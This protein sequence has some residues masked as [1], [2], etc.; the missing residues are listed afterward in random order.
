MNP[1]LGRAV[2]RLARQRTRLDRVRARRGRPQRW[3][4][5]VPWISIGTVVT[6]IIGIG[7]L[8]FTGVATYYG[9]QVSKDQLEQSREES[10]REARSQATKVSFWF[11]GQG[12]KDPVLHVLNRSP[13]PVTHPT[14][15]F[16]ADIFATKDTPDTLALGN[17]NLDVLPPCSLLTVRSQQ[18]RTRAMGES[19]KMPDTYLWL[20]QT[21]MIFVDR[22]G[23]SWGRIDGKLASMKQVEARTR[24]M[25]IRAYK[26]VPLHK[27]VEVFLEHGDK[28][29]TTSAPNCGDDSAK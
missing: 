6:V 14:V 1:L 16:V 28:P 20:S 12:T 10:E 29:R 8:A 9:A 7:S 19:A 3:W 17:I 15:A 2:T 11:E 21:Y 18:L 27:Q 26:G 5:K 4:Q 23:R 25:A 24:S 22:D 13:D